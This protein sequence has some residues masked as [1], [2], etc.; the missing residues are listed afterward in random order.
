MTSKSISRMT[1]GLVIDYVNT[2]RTLPKTFVSKFLTISKALQRAKKREQGKQLE[3]L[4][5]SFDTI[6]PL[7]AL[8]IS[9]GLTLAADTI[10]RQIVN[11]GDENYKMDQKLLDELLDKHYVNTEGIFYI[12]DF[13]DLDNLIT[14]IL[15]SENDPQRTNQA[16]IFSTEYNYIGAASRQ[17]LDEDLNLVIFAK[18]LEERKDMIDY[19]ELAQIFNSLDDKD[20]GFIDPI[21]IYAKLLEYGFEEK[22]PTLVELFR[23][24]KEN[25]IKSRSK[26]KGIDYET[27]KLGAIG[28]H[29]KKPIETKE[30]WKKVFNFFVDDHEA[31]T[32]SIGNLK[33]IMSFLEEEIPNKE[34]KKLMKWGTSS[35]NDMTFDEFYDIMTVK[36]P[37][38]IDEKEVE[39]K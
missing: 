20:S 25:K 23:R 34:L 11:T 30:D 17:F 7:D 36:L 12:L 6:K 10:V 4:A 15:I 28:M 1:N 38:E 39:L 32:I 26:T 16:A 27:F 35:G 5:Q 21:E 18:T 9:D 24:L 22:N 14:R 31:N 8:T 2:L 37:E 13:G 19:D 3:E 33:R 29:I